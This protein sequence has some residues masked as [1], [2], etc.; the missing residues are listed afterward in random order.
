[1]NKILYIDVIC[2]DGHINFNKIYI[3]SLIESNEDVKLIL[4]KGYANK[5]GFNSK[6]VLFE[7]PEFLFYDFKK[8]RFFNRLMMT[9]SLMY[10]NI[11]IL[12]KN[13]SNI[14]IGS[15]E[16]ISFFCSFFGKKTILINHNNI[17]GLSNSLKR[18]F[19]IKLSKKHTMLVFNNQIRDYLYELNIKNVIVKPHGLPEVF[20]KNIITPIRKHSERIIFLPSH[21]SIDVNFIDDAFNNEMLLSLLKEYNFKIVKKGGT[22]YKDS[23][24]VTIDK[25]LGYEEYKSI[26]LES[27]I[28]LLPY[29]S[30]FKYRV[31][32]ILHECFVNDKLCLL[33]NIDAFRVYEGNFN[34]NPFFSDVNDLC[35][36]LSELMISFLSEESYN[37]NYYKNLSEL[38]PIF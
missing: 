36:R 1:M 21:N 23:N 35:R 26:L 31:S 18:F 13:Y 16:E 38:K 17:S 11:R 34:Y 7:L 33:S 10:I 29:P 14:Y 19:F 8:I 9:I 25:V 37:G 6:F 4:K 24:I 2:A 32:G 12:F 28:I 5:M 22:V 27:D 15:Y 20:S 3:N 30:T